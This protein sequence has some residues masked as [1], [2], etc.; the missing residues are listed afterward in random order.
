MLGSDH[1]KGI[2]GSGGMTANAGEIAIP[3][4]S[5][6]E[7]RRDTTRLAPS[8]QSPHKRS[9]ARFNAARLSKNIARD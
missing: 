5:S 2:G 9:C 8:G 1:E 3:G 6:Y 4:K 7:P